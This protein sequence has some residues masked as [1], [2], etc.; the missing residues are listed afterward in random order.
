MNRLSGFV[1]L[2]PYFKVPPD[3]LD[4]LKGIL[5]EFSAKTR[6]ETGNLF[7]EFTIN[8]DEVFCREGY[9]NADALLAH[10]ENVGPMLAQALQMARLVRLEVH[11]PAPEL[12]VLRAPLAHLN[13]V[14][15]VLHR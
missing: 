3:K 12:E 15:F 13:P 2:H 8:G 10:L 1:S 9:V 7:Y 11:G 4:F 14:W 5:P 6:N